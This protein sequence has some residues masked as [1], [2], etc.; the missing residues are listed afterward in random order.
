M[1]EL[2]QKMKKLNKDLDKQKHNSW[3]HINKDMNG[4]AGTMAKLQRTLDAQKKELKGNNSVIT[5]GAG[6]TLNIGG[7]LLLI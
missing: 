2:E 5:V 7:L 4:L 1:K 6:E 3:N